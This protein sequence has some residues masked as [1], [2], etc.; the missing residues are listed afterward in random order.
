ML[1]INAR[2]VYLIFSIFRERS[3]EKKGTFT[4]SLFKI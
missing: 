4:D 2:G 1:R 3:Y